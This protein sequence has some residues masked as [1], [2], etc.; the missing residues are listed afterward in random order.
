L[1]PNQRPGPQCAH[2]YQDR[3][4]FSRVWSLGRFEG[5]LR[6]AVLRAKSRYG[7]LLTSALADLLFDEFRTEWEDDRPDVVLPVP[8]HWTEKL[9][10]DHFASQTAAE[11][12]ALR[13]NCD[14]TNGVIVKQK[15]TR[16]QATLVPS[17]RR[18]NLADAFRLRH[19]D[20]IAGRK[21]MLVDDVLTTGT[22]AHRLASLLRRK[23]GA[24]DV[25]VCVIARGLGQ[26]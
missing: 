19:R 2:C 14:F 24:I 25:R 7:G 15:R 18:R 22:T 1:G 3:F 17:D 5:T 26:D 10:V 20:H 21:V 9:G 13:L 12:L 6:L 11:R 4:A 23:G 16:R 8:H